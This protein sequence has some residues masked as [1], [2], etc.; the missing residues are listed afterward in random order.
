[1]SK[2]RESGENRLSSFSNSFLR[3]LVTS[4]LAAY[5]SASSPLSILEVEANGSI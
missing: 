5:K 4:D 2:Q 1:M 3:Q